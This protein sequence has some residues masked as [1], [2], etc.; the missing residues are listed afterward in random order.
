ME[1]L[2]SG[3]TGPGSPVDL[4]PKSPKQPPV[5]QEAALPAAGGDG[6]EAMVPMPAAVLFPPEEAALRTGHAGRV[7]KELLGAGH[8]AAGRAFVLRGLFSPAE[9]QRAIAWS[10][11][12]QA[13][14]V[15]AHSRKAYRNNDRVVVESAGVAAEMARRIAPFLVDCCDTQAAAGAGGDSADAVAGEAALPAEGLGG[16]VTPSTVVVHAGNRTDFLFDGVGREGAWRFDGLNP[17]LR[18]CRYDPGGH[19]GPHFDGEY[20]DAPTRRSFKTFMVYLNGQ[21]DA[22]AA[23]LAAADPPPTEA[24][25][26]SIGDEAAAA[27]PAP[28]GGGATGFLAD[29][30]LHYDEAAGIF[31]GAPGARLFELKP[32]AGDCLVFDH[33]M[34]HEGGVVASGEKFILRSDV[35]YR[36]VAGAGA[37]E[38][39][40]KYT[41]AAQMLVRAQQLEALGGP[42]NAMAAAALMRR[43]IKVYP[44]IE[45]LL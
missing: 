34:L 41:E 35:M 39:D 42:D 8:C 21:A 26:R 17:C 2:G 1:R 36:Q 20:E 5:L 19:F 10:R 24:T 25:S 27:R 11:E 29:H 16:N 43:A 32:R 38:A 7:R 12:H 44:P 37:T 15:A 6:G 14:M 18:L 22:E 4:P 33:R 3:S 28:F 45:R 40:P 9:C 30:D 13:D 31:C 23:F